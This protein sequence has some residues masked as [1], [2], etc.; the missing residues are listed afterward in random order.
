[1]DLPLLKSFD[2]RFQVAAAFFAFMPITAV[3]Q[4]FPKANYHRGS[5]LFQSPFFD[6]K[7]GPNRWKI[8]ATIGGAKPAFLTQKVALYRAAELSKAAGLSFFR[9]EFAESTEQVSP[10]Y[11]SMG[12]VTRLTI[13]A[14]GTP[15]PTGHCSKNISLD[16][17]TADVEQT[18]IEMKPFLNIKQSAL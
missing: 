13:E 14:V 2:V 7:V 12:G 8:R 16:C 6:T 10:G 17:K 18:L 1:M 3:A 4:D 15:D 5:T 11:G 9:I